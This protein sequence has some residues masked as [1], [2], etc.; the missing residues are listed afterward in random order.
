MLGTS[1][2]LV[3]LVYE[4]RTSALQ[5]RALAAVGRHLTFAVER[6]QSGEILYPSEGPYDSRLGYA[7]L[8]SI[9]PKLKTAGYEIESQVRWSPWMR[10]VIGQGVYPIYREKN[11]AG[12]SVLD[13][14][15]QPLFT[16]LYPQRIYPNFESIPDPVVQ[17]LLFVENRE[18]LDSATPNRNPAIEW[19][20]LIKAAFDVSLNQIDPSHPISGGST[21]ATQLEKIRHSPQGRT[22]SGLEKFRQMASASLRAYHN[23]EQTL[24]TR[25][26]IVCDYLNSLPLA[27]A[28]DYGEVQGLGD[29]LRVWYGADFVGVNRLLS[30]PEASISDQRVRDDASAAY[31]QVLSLILAVNKPS[32]YLQREPA[33]LNARVDSYLR[34]LGEAGIISARRV[35]GSLRIRPMTG[36]T[37]LLQSPSPFS[38][39]KGSDAIRA[40]LVSL[41][42]VGNTYELDRLDLTVHSTL[43]GSVTRGVTQALKELANPAS[44]A[45]AG[46]VGDNLLSSGNLMSSV[47]YSFVLYERGANANLLRAQVD[48]YDRPLN[49]SEGSKL[50]LGS[51]AKLRTLVT[52]L[53]TIA[54]LHKQYAGRELPG[55]QVADPGSVLVNREDRLTGW[56]L[57]YLTAATNRSLPTMLEAAMNRTYSASPEESFFTGGGLHSFSNFDEKDDIRVLTVREAFQRSVNLVFVRLMRDLV[58]YHMFRIGGASSAVQA[59]EGH[60]LRRRYLERFADREGREFLGRFFRR[61]DG[62]SSEEALTTLIREKR[63][64]PYRLAVIHRSVFPEATL[65]QFAAFLRSQP[66]GQALPPKNVEIVY[67]EQEPGRFSWNDRGYLAR[68]HPLELWLLEYRKRHPKATFDEVVEASATERRRVY[69]WLF[70]P[71]RKHGQDLRIRTLIEADA[72]QEIHRS[73]RSLGYPFSAL[74]PSYATAIGS[75]GDTPAALAELAG[76]IS[77]DGLRYPTMRVTK[78][79]F[80]EGTPMGTVM[81]KRVAPPERILPP[82]VAAALRKELLGVVERGTGRRAYGSIVLSDGSRV[83]VGGKTGTGDNRFEIHGPGGKFTESRVVNRTAAFLFTIGDRFFGTIIAY[84]PGPDAGSYHFT[85]AL[86]VQVFK[87]LVPTFRPLIEE[88]R[89]NPGT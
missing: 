27:A 22:S 12:L 87:H 77:N 29:G 67:R 68:V 83:A 86:P 44:A 80:A 88:R 85:S 70:K 5:A 26:R 34:L 4:I 51:T 38:D 75:S 89:K 23:G 1:L 2:L 62:Q 21:L 84:I 50:E 6:G 20:R 3:F 49:M 60:S 65:D 57:E 53:E 36:K 58:R 37:P 19:T 16:A 63:P 30:I 48:N 35:E 24:E 76:I 39:R 33:A 17:T 14:T 32:F 59:E 52:Y 8:P 73:W 66:T 82:A 46:I 78:L 42:G 72:F 41:L 81:T 55:R 61:Y 45:K 31:R 18:I 11:Q 43:D 7:K 56:A 74:V 47:I 9:L 64:T 54:E 79:D 15:G 25:R 69:E 40:A 71:G 10:R 28:P 13:Q